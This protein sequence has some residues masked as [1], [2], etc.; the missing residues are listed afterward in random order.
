MARELKATAP[1]AEV[2]SSNLVCPGEVDPG[3]VQ[4]PRRILTDPAWMEQHHV[5]KKVCMRA[6]LVLI[7]CA[8]FCS[9]GAFGSES[10]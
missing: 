1:E 3:E 5:P 4:T 10:S 2:E 6:K 7:L 8:T 9:S